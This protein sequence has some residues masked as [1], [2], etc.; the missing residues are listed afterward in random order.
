MPHR[1]R[2]VTPPTTASSPPT[3]PGGRPWLAGVL[4]RAARRARRDVPARP[5]TAGPQAQRIHPRTAVLPEHPAPR[6]RAVAAP[7][8]RGARRGYADVRH[9]LPALGELV[10]EVRRG[11]AARAL[12]L[13]DGPAHTALG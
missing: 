13:R 12:D 10:S 8:H 11:G 5:A 6:R 3:L 2:R 7:R 9:G 4:G 1:R